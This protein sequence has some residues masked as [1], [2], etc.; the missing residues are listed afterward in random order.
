MFVVWHDLMIYII[1]CKA[2]SITKTM[3]G[4][5]KISISFHFHS[6][7]ALQCLFTLRIQDLEDD[8]DLDRETSLRL[9][10]LP[11]Q[12]IQDDHRGVAAWNAAGV[13]ADPMTIGIEG[14]QFAAPMIFNYSNNILYNIYIYIC[15]CVYVFVLISHIYIYICF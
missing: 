10:A 1:H 7:S 8:C 13:A 3:N 12:A 14:F 5:S 15:M 2:T 6:S 11:R 4:L 9:R